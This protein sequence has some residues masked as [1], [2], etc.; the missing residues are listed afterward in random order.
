MLT[1]AADHAG[2]ELVG[3]LRRGEDGDLRGALDDVAVRHDDAV[4]AHD[5]PGAHALAG[6]TRGRHDVAGDV[7]DCGKGLARDG[8]DRLVRRRQRLGVA[9][10]AGRRR[11]SWSCAARRYRW[12]MRWRR[13]P[14]PRRRAGR[15]CAWNVPPVVFEGNAP[16]ASPG[17]ARFPASSVYTAFSKEAAG[18]SFRGSTNGIAAVVATMCSPGLGL[19]VELGAR[20]R[21]ARSGPRRSRCS[22]RGPATRRRR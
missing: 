20:L 17:A 22:S 4:G 8:R 12:C 7:D 14:G 6:L 19:D 15:S 11:A 1:V 13:W 18:R 16:Y 2:V 5:E 3:L 9:E 10:R 21:H